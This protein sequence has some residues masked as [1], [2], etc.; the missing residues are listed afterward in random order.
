MF[1]HRTSY[2]I[3]IFSFNW[4]FNYCL[5]WLECNEK[6]KL[7]VGNGEFV[8]IKETC[9]ECGKKFEDEYYTSEL[10]KRIYC[11]ECIKKKWNDRF[12]NNKGL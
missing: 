12:I 5:N 11:N 10:S 9:I 8:E 4:N 1:K 7:Y 2:S 3:R 6:M